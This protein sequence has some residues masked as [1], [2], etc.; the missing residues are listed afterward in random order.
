MSSREDLAVLEK[1]ARAWAMGLDELLQR[2]AEHPTEIELLVTR[3][4]RYGGDAALAGLSRVEI[5]RAALRLLGK[6]D[7]DDDSDAEELPLEAM[8]ES[9]ADIDG[10][11]LSAES[12]A[13]VTGDRIT[14]MDLFTG[15]GAQHVKMSRVELAMLLLKQGGNDGNATVT[16][17]PAPPE[18][19]FR[20]SAKEGELVQGRLH[21]RHQ[22]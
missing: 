14:T 12:Q 21:L 3:T 9:A 20:C 2:A 19:H 1:L 5:S 11:D 18:Q 17:S 22:R 7:E 4:L 13:S 16:R 10:E 15:G 8:C 6:T